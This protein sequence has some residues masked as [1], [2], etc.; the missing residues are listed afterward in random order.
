MRRSKCHCYRQNAHRSKEVCFTSSV[1]ITTMDLIRCP[2][3]Q[4]ACAG[5]EWESPRIPRPCLQTLIANWWSQSLHWPSELRLWSRLS[6]RHSLQLVRWVRYLDCH[7]TVPQVE[8][9]LSQTNWNPFRSMDFNSTNH[10]VRSYSQHSLTI[11]EVA[12]DQSHCKGELS[13][14]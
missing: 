4:S 13:R 10:F 6:A 3:P 7:G 12:L 5:V 9:L 14:H 8:S 2:S 11:T 1:I